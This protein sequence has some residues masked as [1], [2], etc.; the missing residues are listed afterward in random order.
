MFCGRERV[1][2]MNGRKIPCVYKREKQSVLSLWMLLEGYRNSSGGRKNQHLANIPGVCENLLANADPKNDWYLG[3]VGG[4]F[5][6]FFHTTAAVPQGYPLSPVLFNTSFWMSF[7]KPSTTITHSSV[8]GR[9]DLPML[10]RRHRTDGRHRLFG[11][12]GNRD[13]YWQ[14]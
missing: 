9:L 4:Q 10:C 3:A 6:V 12:I 14:E 1:E 2:K 11:Q 8:E 13:Q 7:L 5:G